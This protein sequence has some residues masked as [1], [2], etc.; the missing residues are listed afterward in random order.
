MKHRAHVQWAEGVSH[1]RQRPCS[2]YRDLHQECPKFVIVRSSA[3]RIELNSIQEKRLPVVSANTEVSQS[4]V[5]LFAQWS[6]S[7]CDWAAEAVSCGRD[8][9]LGSIVYPIPHRSVKSRAVV[10]VISNSSFPLLSDSEMVGAAIRRKSQEVYT[11]RV[12]G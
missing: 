6:M 8:R 12:S 11:K 2:N 4:N 10:D 1:Y 7:Q 9:F 3:A 5:P